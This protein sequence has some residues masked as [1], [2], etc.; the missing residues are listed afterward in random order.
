[1]VLFWSL[2]LV[3]LAVSAAAVP[4]PDPTYAALRAARPDGAGQQPDPGAGRLPLPVRVGDLPLPGAGRGAH[5]GGGVR[6]ARELPAQPGH[7]ERAEAPRPRLR[8]GGRVRDVHR[9]L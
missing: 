2:L 8:R 9:R 6:G 5:G 4:A 1:M 7:G 3:S